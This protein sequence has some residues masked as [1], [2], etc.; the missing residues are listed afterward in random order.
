[1]LTL[2]TLLQQQTQQH[3]SKGLAPQR[4]EDSNFV[5]LQEYL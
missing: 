5:C 1:M 2:P 3:H 4:V